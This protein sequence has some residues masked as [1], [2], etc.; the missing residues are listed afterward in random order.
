MDVEMVPVLVPVVGNENGSEEGSGEDEY[1]ESGEEESEEESES[2][3][4]SYTEEEDGESDGEEDEEEPVLKYKRFAKEVVT[5]IN[6]PG[7]SDIMPIHICCIA[8]HSKVNSWFHGA[9]EPVH[10]TMPT[11]FVIECCTDL[12]HFYKLSNHN[13]CTGRNSPLPR[14]PIHA[15]KG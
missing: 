13:P 8:V 14:P 4:G 5:S 12:M 10:D 11:G 15:A 6:D 7:V 9:W 3:S 1:S 2:G